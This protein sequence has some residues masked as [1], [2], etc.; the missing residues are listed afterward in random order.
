ME[1]AT[2]AMILQWDDRAASGA[3]VN[4]HV[5]LLPMDG[6]GSS[7]ADNPFAS[8]STDQLQDFC[9][10]P[11]CTVRLSESEYVIRVGLALLY[12]VFRP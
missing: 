2:V 6:T 12:V 3:W 8:C 10:V 9:I 7:M 11:G 1:G 5:D 4:Q